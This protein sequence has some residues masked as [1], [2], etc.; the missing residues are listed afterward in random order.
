[1]HRKLWLACLLFAGAVMSA[2]QWEL[3]GESSVGKH[4]IDQSSVVRNTADQKVTVQT[5][6]EQPDASIW[7]T[8]MQVDCHTRRFSYLKGFQLK[9]GKQVVRFDAPRAEEPIS[10][11]SLPDQLEQRYCAARVAPISAPVP[12]W[13]I[14]SNSNAGEVAIDRASLQALPGQEFKVNTRVRLFNKNEQT[15]SSLQFNCGKGTFR[16]LQSQRLRDGHAEFLFDKPQPDVPVSK[17]ATTQELAKT[18]CTP[19][20]KPARTPFQEDACKATLHDLQGLETRVQADVDAHALYCD[21]MQNYLDHLAKIADEVEKNHC[22]IHGL[23]QY[24]REIR[25]VG[26]EDPV[27]GQ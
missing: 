24:Q 21:T 16:I 2:E 12:S 14:V 11:G 15:L 19:A 9:D 20:A 3:A 6:V 8:T 26:C 10:P 13:E 25:A 4:Y 5:K 27:N 17:S 1:M 7:V 18:I 23:D 22:A